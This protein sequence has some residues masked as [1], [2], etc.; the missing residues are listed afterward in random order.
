[1]FHVAVCDDQKQIRKE[2]LQKI[3]EYR[4]HHDLEE[5]DWDIKE[6]ATG[7]ELLEAPFLY[8]LY[9]LDLEMPD[10]DGILIAEQLRRQWGECNI[11]ILTSHLER[12]KEGYKVEAFRYMT[13]PLLL[14]ELEEGLEA[15]RNS[16]IGCEVV[17]LQRRGHDFPVLQRDIRYICR[18]NG[19]TVLYVKD[20]RFRSECSLEEWERELNRAV[21]FRCHRG[22]LVN[23]GCIGDI[24]K[25]IV[26]ISGERIPISRRRRNELIESSMEFDL[27]YGR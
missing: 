23:M 1:M 26:L 25:E 11:M 15:F 19:D 2:L 14:E 22:Y 21:F 12:M 5:E 6:F 8:D 18:E 9:F 4:K 20:M 13:K 10:V 7:K 17:H 16:R 3:G 24:E 27:K